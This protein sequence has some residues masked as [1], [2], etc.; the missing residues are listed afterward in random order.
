MSVKRYNGIEVFM[1]INEFLKQKNMTGYRLSK[2]S[3][4]PQTTVTDICSG[5]TAIKNCTAE[6][7]YRLS[8]VLD[9]PMDSLIE[10]ELEA[11]PTFEI[12]KSHICHMVKDMG[13]VDFIIATLSED[14][15]RKLY[16][17]QWY[18][19]SLYLLAMVDYLCRENGLPL[20]VEYND[21]RGVRL[22]E[23]IY[24][25]SIIAL[26]VA[27]N[28][29]EPKVESLNIAIPEFARFNIV[30]NEVRNVY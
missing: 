14:R 1:S 28:S 9:V 30:E 13:D 4:I 11:R 23:T 26:S 27:S 29:D 10:M 17:K 2:L 20:C 19:E 18:P 6:T 24:P 22:A 15:I 8:K 16:Q 7:V 21:L 5:K 3:G 25:A 12:F